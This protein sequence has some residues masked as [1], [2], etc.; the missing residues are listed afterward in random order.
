[1]HVLRVC[2]LSAGT[3]WTFERRKNLAREEMMDK[4]RDFVIRGNS[5]GSLE[6][7]AK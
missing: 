7:K 1:M 5:R 6:I 2:L 3:G 4:E